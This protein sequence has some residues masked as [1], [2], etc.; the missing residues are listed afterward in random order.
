MSTFRKKRLVAFTAINLFLFFNSYASDTLNLKKH[1]FSFSLNYQYNIS[2]GE[3][4]FSYSAGSGPTSPQY[5]ESGT[6]ENTHGYKGQLI[7]NKHI[8]PF[9]SFSFGLEIA[10]YQTLLKYESSDHLY[11]NS[12]ISKYSLKQSFAIISSYFN[13][14][15]NRLIISTGLKLQTVQ[16]RIAK[17][18]FQS[19]E[20]QTLYSGITTDGVL[21]FSEQFYCQFL[22]Q[23]PNLHLTTGVDIS[24]S[25]SFLKYKTGYAIF[26]EIGI[27]IGL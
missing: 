5:T 19:S 20:E 27:C 6:I 1:F 4:K 14:H 11:N 17:E 25:K 15:K 9:Y 21:L 12:P 18:I 24:L 16:Y 3:K 26:P 7:Y 13:A 2:V 10:K 8:N 22:E 23:R